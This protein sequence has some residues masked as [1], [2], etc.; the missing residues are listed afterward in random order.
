M[1]VAV[2]LA[3]AAVAGCSQSTPAPVVSVSQVSIPPGLIGTQ[4]GS[5]AKTRLQ[6][7]VLRRRDVPRSWASMPHQEAS[8]ASQTDP[9]ARC[10]LRS[11]K[12]D[13][14]LSVN[15]DDFAR[16]TAK[17]TSSATRYSSEQDVR[18][19]V[20]AL[21]R[22]RFLSCLRR[23]FR[24]IMS[25][26]LAAGIEMRGFH[27]TYQPRRAGAPRNV[28]GSITIRV[29]AAS[30]VRQA[31]ARV[32]IVFIAGPRLEAMV[33]AQAINSPVPTRLLDRLTAAVAR[34][35]DRA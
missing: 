26:Q 8:D 16:G 18:G 17:I 15:S 21:H 29:T 23:D 7:I 20:R 24:R 14:I 35:A 22:P 34:R 30:S 3:A 2:V 12:G 19:D 31:T 6:R 5:T 28:V 13:A 33:G 25:G 11:T 1:G 10:G 27:M 32:A 4:H 9:V